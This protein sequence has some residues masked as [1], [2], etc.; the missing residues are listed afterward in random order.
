MYVN[1]S[2]MC[3]TQ[4]SGGTS[5]VRS[6]LPAYGNVSTDSGYR[7]VNGDPSGRSPRALQRESARAPSRMNGATVAAV[8]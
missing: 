2:F 3:R 5:R 4:G 1:A 6:G 7:L 8:D